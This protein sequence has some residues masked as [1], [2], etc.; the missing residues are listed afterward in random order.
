MCLRG[1]DARPPLY[2][3]AKNAPK[4]RLMKSLGLQI[5]NHRARYALVEA[6]ARQFRVLEQGEAELP[7]LAKI[8]S[9]ASRIILGLNIANL[10]YRNVE[11]RFSEIA[12]HEYHAYYCLR[13]LKRWQE[14]SVKKSWLDSLIL[15]LKQ[16]GLKIR[17]V[18]CQ[19]IA[20]MRLARYRGLAIADQQNWRLIEPAAVTLWSSDYFA[21]ERCAVFHYQND[22]A[23]IHQI[24]AEYKNEFSLQKEILIRHND[25]DLNPLLGLALWKLI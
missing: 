21:L 2:C 4:L 14:L 3:K 23:Q 16:Q 11:K 5:E 15:I 25:P 17:A 24:I 22:I 9:R 6:R 20:A 10:R 8:A 7:E 18:D 19:I 12:S 13:K 1:N